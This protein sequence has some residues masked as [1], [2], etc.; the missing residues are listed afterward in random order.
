MEWPSSPFSLAWK[1]SPELSVTVCKIKAS[2]AA[3]ALT[4]RYNGLSSPAPMC[5]CVYA[6]GHV[7][8]MCVY[9]CACIIHIHVGC[10][11][12]AGNE[13]SFLWKSN[14]CF[15]LLSHL[16][17]PFSFASLAFGIVLAQLVM[18]NH[19]HWL[20]GMEAEDMSTLRRLTPSI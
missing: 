6:H 1:A 17:M 13:L 7:R 5:V 19:W 16:S 3:C 10:H 20:N 15:R 14:Q 12:S 2:Y 18:L 11:V 9:V 4:S 8:Y